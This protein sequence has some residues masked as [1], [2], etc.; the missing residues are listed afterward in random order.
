MDHTSLVRRLAP[1]RLLPQRKRVAAR[2]PLHSC[3]RTLMLETKARTITCP[4]QLYL[5][6]PS[7]SFAPTTSGAIL[8][9][10]SSHPAHICRGLV[11]S[12]HTPQSS[13]NEYRYIPR[14]CATRTPPTHPPTLDKST[15]TP[16]PCAVYA[17]LPQSIADHG[18]HGCVPRLARGF[19]PQGSV[20]HP[21]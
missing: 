8:P 4:I 12:P 1:T 15:D 11:G 20:F 13:A 9:H 3:C 17:A 10:T 14:W 5:Q 16:V 2:A 21:A 6:N 19:T 7:S 18:T